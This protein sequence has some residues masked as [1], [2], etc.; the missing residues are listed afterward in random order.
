MR[1]GRGSRG[2][3]VAT[4]L[5]GA[6]VRDPG[7]GILA[8]VPHRAG[9]TPRSQFPTLP[10]HGIHVG[11]HAFCPFGSDGRHPEI[12]VANPVGSAGMTGA[13][14]RRASAGIPSS[15]GRCPGPT[16]MPLQVPG[17]QARERRTYPAFPAMAD[18]PYPDAA[19]LEVLEPVLRIG[20]SPAGA[21]RPGSASQDGAIRRHRDPPAGGR[22]SRHD[23]AA[24]A[25][26]GYRKPR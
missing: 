25:G 12:G 14:V 26:T 11:T 7:R 4:G 21:H 22:R 13:R 10:F 6:L 2:H 3:A 20:R 9:G 24:A 5:R 1:A 15:N 16:K 19:P 8:G 17:R 18:G 23:A